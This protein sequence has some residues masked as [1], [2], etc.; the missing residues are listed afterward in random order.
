[1]IKCG[2]ISFSIKTLLPGVMFMYGYICLCMVIYVY[3]WRQ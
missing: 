1:L 2:N 3:V